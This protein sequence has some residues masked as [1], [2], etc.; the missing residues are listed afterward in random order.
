MMSVR[1]RCGGRGASFSPD[2]S[3]IPK[4]RASSSASL[5]CFL[6]FPNTMLT[7]LLRAVAAVLG[8]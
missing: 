1:F 3:C 6:L 5:S 8:P 2:G 7:R 4:P